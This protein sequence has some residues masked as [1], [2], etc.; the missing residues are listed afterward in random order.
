VKINVKDHPHY[1]WTKEC[2]GSMDREALKQEIVMRGIAP[3]QWTE[4]M[5]EGRV[6]QGSGKDPQT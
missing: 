1:A 6:I 4:Y 3:A 5:N 2:F